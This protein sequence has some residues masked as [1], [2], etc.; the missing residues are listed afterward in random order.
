MTRVCATGQYMSY[1]HTKPGRSAGLADNSMAWLAS[2]DSVRD[3]PM[4]LY[5]YPQP[6]LKPQ[7]E[8]V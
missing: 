2:R 3:I 8:H 6:V 4:T 7:L 1:E 5:S